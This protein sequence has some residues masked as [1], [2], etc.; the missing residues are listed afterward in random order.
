[1]CNG[2]SLSWLQKGKEIMPERVMPERG[3]VEIAVA[4]VT[5]QTLEHVQKCAHHRAIVDQVLRNEEENLSEPRER[6][7]NGWLAIWN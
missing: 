3:Q 1:M 4:L 6:S 5:A 2:L 7:G